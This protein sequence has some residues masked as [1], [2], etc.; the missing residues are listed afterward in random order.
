[1]TLDITRIGRNRLSD[2]VIE[3]IVAQIAAG[4]LKRGDKL[5]P[6]PVLMQQFGVGRSSIREAMGALALMGVISVRPG[7]GTHITVSPE[8]FLARPLS[9]GIPMGRQSVQEFIDARNALEKSIIELAVINATE[10]DLAE[11]KK[12][13][14][15]MIKNRKSGRKA[16]QADLAFHMALAEASH[17]NVLIGF[18]KQLRHLMKSAMEQKLIVIKTYDSVI[19]QHREIIDALESRNVEKACQTIDKHLRSLEIK[20]DS[21]LFK[22]ES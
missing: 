21:A 7:H 14:N 13:Q 10:E 11:I 20:L 3:Q 6:E 8:E 19:T 4:K 12:Q 5:P 17:N 9:W 15:L 2:L 1:M 22:G 16:I 18:L